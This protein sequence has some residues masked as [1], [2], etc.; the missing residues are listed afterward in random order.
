MDAVTSQTI[1]HYFN[2]L[3]KTLK[4]NNLLNKLAQIDETG[5]LSANK[6]VKKVKSHTSGNKAQTMEVVVLM[7][8]VRASHSM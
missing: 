4:D 6:G 7:R 1:K 8:S 5:T 2:L 3:E